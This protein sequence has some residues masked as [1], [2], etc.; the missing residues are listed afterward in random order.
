MALHERR[1]AKTRL[2]ILVIVIQ[3]KKWI[4]WCQLI[5][6]FFWYDTD[7]RSVHSILNTFLITS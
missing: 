5:Q 4:A 2:K 1:H 3:K 6:S 7:Y